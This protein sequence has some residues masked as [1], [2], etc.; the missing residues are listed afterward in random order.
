MDSTTNKEEVKDQ[1]DS[2]VEDTDER[3]ELE[4]LL[5]EDVDDLD[6]DED[7]DDE[8]EDAKDSGSITADE[9]AKIVESVVDRR[10]NK[11]MNTKQKRQDK[12]EQRDD[13]RNS[14]SAPT[15]ADLREARASYREFV[16]DHVRFLSAEEREY[17]H[18][19]AA[20][21][22]KDE[23]VS[24]VDADVAGQRVAEK[25]GEQVVALRRMYEK[26]AIAQLRKK[27][28]LPKKT[29]QPFSADQSNP[30]SESR[31]AAGKAQAERLY[32]SRVAS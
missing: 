7:S 8:D 5:D 3:D 14:S 29:G 32:S 6:A 2:G 23:L 27:G 30:G 4:G 19:L 10:I 18:A 20:G 22:L 15:A 1:N 28:L 12:R 31:Y 11:L 9:V 25:V 21:M 26:R 24:D 17:A 13:D 16:G